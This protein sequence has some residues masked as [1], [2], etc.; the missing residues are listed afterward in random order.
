MHKRY[1]RPSESSNATEDSNTDDEKESFVNGRKRKK[2]SILWRIYTSPFFKLLPL[3][4]VIGLPLWGAFFAMPEVLS[5]LEISGIPYYLHTIISLWSSVMFAYNFMATMFLNPGRLTSAIQPHDALTGQYTIAVPERYKGTDLRHINYAPRYCN[6]CANWKPP[7]SHHCS[8][9]GKCT[10]RM[11]HHC[12]VVGNCVGVR[13][14]GNFILMYIF[15]H[16]SL[17]H[18]LILC[19]WAYWRA[20]LNTEEHRAEVNKMLN[21]MGDEFPHMHHVAF[22]PVAFFAYHIFAAVITSAGQTT[23]ISV[24]IIV[25]ALGFVYTCGGPAVYFAIKNSTLLESQLDVTS[26]YAQIEENVYCPLGHLFF[27]HPLRLSS[28]LPWSQTFFHG[29]LGKGGHWRFLLPIQCKLD[30]QFLCTDPVPSERGCEH[31]LR[32][33]AEAN[34]DGVKREVGSLAA[35]GI[36]TPNARNSTDVI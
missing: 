30:M 13:N 1:T 20:P 35:L 34:N 29:L 25:V 31:L 22:G 28:V 21:P 3:S 36:D 18:V 7:R 5:L 2:A 8:T 4:V 10:L 33:I 32:R 16:F 24:V 26:E 19:L 14:H 15:A 17:M 23:A 27:S 11:D 12:P 9:C 6:P